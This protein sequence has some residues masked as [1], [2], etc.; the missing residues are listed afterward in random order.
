MNHQNAAELP[1]FR[2][3]LNAPRNQQLAQAPFAVP[4]KYPL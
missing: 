2:R 1:P 4:G 3:D